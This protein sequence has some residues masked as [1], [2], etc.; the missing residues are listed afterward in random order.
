MLGSALTHRLGARR[1]AVGAAV[2]LALGL[3]A[4]GVQAQQ[5][6]EAGPPL[7]LR[8][9]VNALT[10]GKIAKTP[11]DP[12]GDFSTHSFGSNGATL[13]FIVMRHLGLSIS[14]QFQDRHYTNKAGVD[15]REDWI[16]TYYSLTA[17]ARATGHRRGNAFLGYS[18][19]TVDHYTEKQAGTSVPPFDPARNLPLTR[20]FAGFEYTFDRIGFRAEWVE[21]DS[22]DKI[23]GQKV[24]LNQTLQVLSVYIPFN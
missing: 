10:A 5:G 1:F 14:Q 19:G 24:N 3:W 21:F 2:A 4:G 7:Q 18:T 17:Y 8:L 16:N 20:V 6:G 11:A 23:S 13:E 9:Y 12:L 15:T 22:A